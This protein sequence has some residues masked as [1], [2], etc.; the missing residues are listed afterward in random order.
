MFQI[1]VPAL[2]LS[3]HSCEHGDIPAKQCIS[4]AVSSATMV[5]KCRSRKTTMKAYGMKNKFPG[6]HVI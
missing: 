2:K 1:M 4:N 3:G 5:N 6:M